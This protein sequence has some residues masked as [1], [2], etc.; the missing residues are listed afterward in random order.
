MTYEEALAQFDSMTIK[1]VWDDGQSV[2]LGRHEI[3]PWS[4]VDWAQYNCS[5][6]EP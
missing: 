1:A 2:A 4:S 3:L 6:T 5:F